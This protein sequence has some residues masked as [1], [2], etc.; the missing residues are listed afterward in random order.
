ME[1]PFAFKLFHPNYFNVIHVK[2]KNIYNV[3]FPT[4]PCTNN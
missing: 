3:K 2:K 4:T 1:S